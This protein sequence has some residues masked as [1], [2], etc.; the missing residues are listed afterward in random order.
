MLKKKAI[1]KQKLVLVFL[2]AVIITNYRAQNYV[3][4]GSFD[5]V[6][7]NQNYI[8][9]IWDTEAW[10]GTSSVDWYHVYNTEPQIV[11]Q[12]GTPYCVTVPK[13]WA[14]W[15]QPKTGL[16]YAGFLGY[17][18]LTPTIRE[19]PFVALSDTLEIGKPYCVS[20]FVSLA[21]TANFAHSLLSAC[22]ITDTN[23]LYT[24]NYSS[25]TWHAQFNPQVTNTTGFLSSKTDWMKVEG[26]FVADSAYTALIIGEFSNVTAHDTLRVPGGNI[27]APNPFS[28]YYLD[29]VS[30]TELDEPVNAAATDTIVTNEFTFIQLGDSS[31]INATYLWS[32]SLNISNVNSP[33]PNLYVTQSGWY[34]VQ[35][36]QCSYVTYDSV[37]IKA[38]PV[39]IV[40]YEQQKKQFKLYPNPNNGLFELNNKTGKAISGK[41]LVTDLLGKHIMEQFIKVESSIAIDLTEYTLKPGVYFVKLLSENNEVIY[42][43]KVII[44]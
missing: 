36:T 26:Y 16:A 33:S 17:Y 14:G 32:P 3:P 30:V 9:N 13:N 31:N 28:Y 12:C 2:L 37:Y 42:V 5:L 25:P 22:F 20:F 7:T 29:D 4:N 21:D 18:K 10:S 19:L 6:D 39:G 34:Y 44:Q 38:N 27:N 11:T 23:Y 15:Q 1:I 41:Y 35:K 24:I 40:D 8:S 43:G